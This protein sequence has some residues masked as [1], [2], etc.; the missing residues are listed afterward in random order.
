MLTQYD[1]LSG[2]LAVKKLVNR[3][4]NLIDQH[5]DTIKLRSIHVKSLKTSKEKL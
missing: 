5:S 2:E 4:Y 1:Q 3:F